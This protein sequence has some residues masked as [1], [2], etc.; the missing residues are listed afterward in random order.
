M[1]KPANAAAAKA[2]AP[3]QDSDV[4]EH[5]R[6]LDHPR[7]RE[8]AAARKLILGADAKVSEAIK[9][10]APSFRTDDFFAT[11]NLRATDQLQI[12]FHT[13]AKAKGKVVQGKIADPRG[14]LRWL[15]K[16]RA[17]ASLGAGKAFDANKTALT[18]LVRAWLKQL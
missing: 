11:I 17:I 12:I 18:A 7:K 2:K 3:A 6:S 13:G 5:I 10:Q 8:I 16:D 14:L 15:A 9:W 4:A 1:R